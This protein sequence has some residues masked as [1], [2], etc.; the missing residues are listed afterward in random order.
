MLLEEA[1]KIIEMNDKLFS[2]GNMRK[3]LDISEAKKLEEHNRTQLISG[4][5]H[6]KLT[7]KEI[8]AQRINS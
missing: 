2:L 5:A 1:G 4:Q 8:I 6:T 3:K 7:M